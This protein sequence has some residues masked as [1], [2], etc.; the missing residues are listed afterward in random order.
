VIPGG[1]GAGRMHGGRED[2]RSAAAAAAEKERE[3]ERDRER[4]SA[5]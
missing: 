4:G 3:R 2:I 1:W 5:S